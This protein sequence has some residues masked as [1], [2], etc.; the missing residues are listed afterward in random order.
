MLQSRPS[1]QSGKWSLGV[2]RSDSVFC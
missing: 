1:R 2:K